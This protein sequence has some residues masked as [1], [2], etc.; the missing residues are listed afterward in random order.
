MYIHMI[1]ETVVNIWQNRFSKKKKKEYVTRQEEINFILNRRERN[2]IKKKKLCTRKNKSLVFD[3][4]FTSKTIKIIH[5]ILYIILNKANMYHVI[6]ELW[7][8]QECFQSLMI[9]AS[10]L[11]LDL[12]FPKF[13]KLDS[14]GLLA[15][16]WLDCN[17]TWRGIW[18]IYEAFNS[19][20]SDGC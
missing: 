12:V 6:R 9:I 1:E 4:F 3:V 7:L 13:G 16:I 8:C 14:E 20:G 5:F 15:S 11:E 10:L 2:K 18:A 19:I 17:S